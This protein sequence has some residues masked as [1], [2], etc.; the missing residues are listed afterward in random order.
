MK[1]P[2]WA[3]SLY[4]GKAPI[5]RRGKCDLQIPMSNNALETDVAGAHLVHSLQS[6][7]KV[8]FLSDEVIL[9]RVVVLADVN[10]DGRPDIIIGN[11]RGHSN[12]LLINQGHGAFKE[13]A[14]TLP[15]DTSDTLAIGVGDLNNDGFPD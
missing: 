1:S 5:C 10:G 11:G 4:S 7:A 6:R 2:Y 3:G 14:D 15:D 13:E 8:E 9:T 12:Q